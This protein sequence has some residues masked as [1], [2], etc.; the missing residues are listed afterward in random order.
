MKPGSPAPR[1]HWGNFALASS[2]E[3]QG[4]TDMI[5]GPSKL[6]HLIQ[7]RSVLRFL[8]SL[9]G[10]GH[11][12]RENYLQLSSSGFCELMALPS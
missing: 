7:Q 1:E 6:R 9:V 8:Q 10:S 4:Y 2:P 5:H 11:L 3:K 12:S